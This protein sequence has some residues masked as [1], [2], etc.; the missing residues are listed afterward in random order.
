MAWPAAGPRTWVAGE[1]TTSTMYNAH[2]RDTQLFLKTNV[3]DLG[4]LRPGLKHFAFSLGQGNAGGG[5]DTQLT[6]YDVTIPAGALAKPG[7][8]LLLESEWFND[9][10]AGTRTLKIKVGGGTLQTLFATSTASAFIPSRYLVR[11]RTSTT[12]VITGMAWNVATGSGGVTTPILVNLATGTVDWSVAQT[13]SMFAAATNA[14]QVKLADHRVT[15]FLSL[16][17][18]VI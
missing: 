8:A 14:N 9:A 15:Y 12:G 16:I 18:V 13:L 6:S 1:L 11:R 2:L 4:W 7:D 3:H 17:G 10:T 5:G